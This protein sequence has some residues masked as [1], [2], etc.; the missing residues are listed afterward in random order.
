MRLIKVAQLGDGIED[1]MTVLEQDGRLPG[2]LDLEQGLMAQASRPQ[3]A[4]LGGAER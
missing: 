2:A 1:R 4:A 3:E